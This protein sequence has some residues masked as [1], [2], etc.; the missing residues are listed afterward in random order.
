MGK[1]GRRDNRGMGRQRCMGKE[2]EN[3][4]WSDRERESNASKYATQWLLNRVQYQHV[5]CM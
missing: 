4:E 5:L 1:E 3:D 2:G